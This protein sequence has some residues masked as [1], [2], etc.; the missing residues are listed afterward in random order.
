M[1][2][3]RDVLDYEAIDKIS[4]KMQKKQPLTPKEKELMEQEVYSIRIHPDYNK[5]RK[6]CKGNS[7]VFYVFRS[8]IF[9]LYEPNYSCEIADR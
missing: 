8:P 7:I 4:E 5:L 3:E 2:I 9:I 1:Q 6:V